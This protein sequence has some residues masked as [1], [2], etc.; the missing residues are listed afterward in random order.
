[1][2]NNTMITIV[3]V[4]GS[5][6]VLLLRIIINKSL[7]NFHGQEN[8]KAEN[9]DSSEALGINAILTFLI[10]IS[11]LFYDGCTKNDEASYKA[12]YEHIYPKV[13]NYLKELEKKAY[14]K[15]RDDLLDK[16]RTET[17]SSQ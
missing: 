3:F 10:F 6:I 14:E 16:M 1:M 8:T 12:K 2:D 13:D 15:G 4:T 7:F 9:F 11:I 17:S 5:L